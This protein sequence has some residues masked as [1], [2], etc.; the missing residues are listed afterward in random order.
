MVVIWEKK[1]TFNISNRATI[2]TFIKK[3]F[4]ASPIK[5]VPNLQHLYF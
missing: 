3:K 2:V 5:M 4:A 1:S